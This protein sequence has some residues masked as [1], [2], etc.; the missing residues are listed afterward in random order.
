[1]SIGNFDKLY[2]GMGIQNQGSPQDSGAIVKSSSPGTVTV[3]VP[4]NADG[5]QPTVDHGWALV[6]ATALN[7]SAVLGATSL[8]ASD[9]SATEYVGA[10]PIPIASP[11]AG[12]GACFMVPIFSSLVNITTIKTLTA[13]QVT[14]S[15]TNWTLELRFCYG[16]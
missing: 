1:M 16:D 3:T 10:V 9:G 11:T 8:Y 6:T 4:A 12:Q 15:N 13:S 14:T 5:T 2:T 7:G